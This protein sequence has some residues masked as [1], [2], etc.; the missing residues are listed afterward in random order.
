MSAPLQVFPLENYVTLT[1]LGAERRGPSRSV[2]MPFPASPSRQP[3]N[4]TSPSNL[5]RIS[6]SPSASPTPL[7]RLRS[8]ACSEGDLM[9]SLDEEDKATDEKRVFEDNERSRVVQSSRDKRN[10]RRIRRQKLVRGLTDVSTAGKL[11]LGLIQIIAKVIR[12]KKR[13]WTKGRAVNCTR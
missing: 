8:R 13:V 10:P 3:T 4:M 5:R 11:K 2:T 1:D 12:L 6:P 7:G 9:R